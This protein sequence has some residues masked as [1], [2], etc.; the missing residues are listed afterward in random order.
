ME[1]G[2]IPMHID[3]ITHNI[4]SANIEAARRFY[5][6]SL[7]L[8]EIPAVLDPTGKRLIWFQLG[9]GQL[10][11]SIRDTADKSTSR[12]FAVA[13][14]NF[15]LIVGRLQEHGAQTED[16]DSGKLWRVRPD[17]I[18]STFCYDPDGN[19]IELLDR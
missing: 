7:G 10:H 19:R 6:K 16:W 17:G 3:H 4:S 8:T 9:E 1:D 13:L 14:P 5:G 12:H 15:D 11:L 2:P 18:R